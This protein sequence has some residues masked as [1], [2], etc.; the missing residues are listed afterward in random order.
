MTATASLGTGLCVSLPQLLACRLLLG[1][2]S[3]AAMA[4]STAY[5][6]DITNSAPSYRAKLL[7]FQST[8]INLAYALG[9]AVGGFLCDLYGARTSFFVVGGAAL[10]ASVGFS[11]LPETRA[12]EIVKATDTKKKEEEEEEQKE[13]EKRKRDDSSALSRS[14]SFSQKIKQMSMNMPTTWEVYRPLLRSPDQQAVMAMNF[15]VC[16][17]YSCLLAVFPLHVVEV[18]ER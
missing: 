13:K 9:P 6:A 3:S 5:M 2:G 14:P 16:S 8:V 7:G 15:A 17:S 1:A 18:L 12:E 10:V 4:G 11:F